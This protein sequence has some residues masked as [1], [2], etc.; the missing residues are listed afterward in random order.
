MAR[1]AASKAKDRKTSASPPFERVA[2]LLQGGGALGAYQGGVYQALAEANVLPTWIAG[3]SIGAVNSAIIAGNPP[4][5]RVARLREFWE[6]VSASPL[7][8]FGIPYS[9]SINLKDEAMHRLVNQI[10]ALGVALLGAPSFF[11]PRIPPPHIW[12]RQQLGQLSF[13]DVSPLTATLERLV[14]FDRINSREI[15]FSVGAVNLQSGNFAY[16]DNTTHKIDARHIVASGSLPPG[17]PATDVDG[18]FYW[19]G[20]L[21]SNTPLLWVL[22]SEPRRDTLAFQV[23][24]WSSSGELPR[25]MTQ[26]DV[27]Q[28]EIQFASRTRFVT[29]HFRKQQKLRHAFRHVYERLPPEF[30][31]G[32]NLEMLKQEADESAYNIVELIYHS[33]TYEG[34]AKDYEFSRLTMEEHWRSGHEDAARALAHPEIFQR[35]NNLE[36]FQSFD[37]S[38]T[39]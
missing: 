20:G 34:I 22:D 25:D 18:E 17:F 31:D 36:R 3:I 32:P 23:D 1:T 35:A 19:D 15:R 39:A 27:R 21:V 11:I 2:L 4:E 5:K 37:F 10:Q 7:G 12:S 6:A 9:A 38:L 14:D 26:A 30:R 28:K 29:D 8:V 24:L 16:F 13:Y 33:K